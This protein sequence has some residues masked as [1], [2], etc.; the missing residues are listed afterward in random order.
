MSGLI[1]VITIYSYVGRGMQGNNRD[2]T[3]RSD[4]GDVH[5]NVAKNRPRILLNFFT[6]IPIRPVT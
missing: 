2:L 1:S 4:N 3:I 5:E 6:I